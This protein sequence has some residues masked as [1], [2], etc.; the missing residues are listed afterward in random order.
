MDEKKLEQ[1]QTLDDG[2]LEGVSGGARMQSIKMSP[3]ARA[4]AQS[5]KMPVEARA[6]CADDEDLDEG[7]PPLPPI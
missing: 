6:C 1:V 5:I 4:C 2:Q 3:D 7:I